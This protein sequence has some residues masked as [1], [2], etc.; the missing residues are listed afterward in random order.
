M[1]EQFNIV[2]EISLDAKQFLNEWINRLDYLNTSMRSIKK[3]QTDCNL[4]YNCIHNPDYLDLIHN[5]VVFDKVRRNNGSFNYTVY[6]EGLKLISRI[7]THF[8]LDEYSYNKF[9]LYLFEGED[10]VKKKIKLQLSV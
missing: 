2:N 7:T 10:K 1:F 4:L 3:L 8:E 5:G 6:L 9:K